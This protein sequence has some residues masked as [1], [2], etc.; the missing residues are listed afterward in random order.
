MSNENPWDFVEHDEDD[1]R[2]KALTFEAIK[3]AIRQ[4]KDGHNL[5]LAIHPDD[6]PEDLFRDYVGA[7]Y[8]VAMVR[9][10]DEGRPYDRRNHMGNTSAPKSEGQKLVTSA[11]MLC[12]NEEFQVWLN[13]KGYCDELGEDAAKEAMLQL[14]GAES[15]R[16]IATDADVRKRFVELRGAFSEE[17]GYAF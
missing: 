14:I 15:R 6:V 1:V 10:D 3:T 16:E 2:S 11:A 17:H 13:S 4:T 7:R 5:T 12:K 8:Q 9:M